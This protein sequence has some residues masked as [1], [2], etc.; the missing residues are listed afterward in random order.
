MHFPAGFF[1]HNACEDVQTAD[2][3]RPL[4]DVDRL[5]GRNPAMPPGWTTSEVHQYLLTLELIPY[6]QPTYNSNL[7][8]AADANDVLVASKIIL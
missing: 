8:M 2:W 4:D 3:T 5:I 1:L 7:C 6:A